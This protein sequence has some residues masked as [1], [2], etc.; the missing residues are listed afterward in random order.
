MQGVQT[1][2][3]QYKRFI[4]IAIAVI[5]VFLLYQKFVNPSQNTLSP[6]V[7]SFE[8]NS[9][10]LSSNAQ[11][12]VL[13]DTKNEKVGFIQVAVT[14]DTTK[15][16]LKEE[17]APNPAF[18]TVITNSTVDEAN[19]SGNI[20][21]AIGLQ[22]GSESPSGVFEIG[23]LQFEPKNSNELVTLSIDT[24]SSQIVTM[25]AKPVPLEKKDLSITTQ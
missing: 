23:V 1:F 3:N 11:I 5:I 20:I 18:K 24:N 16:S 15:L 9:E 12:K 7:V 14:F 22:P 13:V 10:L 19:A 6:A 8:P 2:Y 25:D 4:F 17:M 21:L